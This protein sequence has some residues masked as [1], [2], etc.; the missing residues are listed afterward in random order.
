MSDVNSPGSLDTK[1]ENYIFVCMLATVPA[2]SAN[3]FV[4]AVS[5]LEWLG[6]GENFGWTGV[7]LDWS[8]SGIQPIRVLFA[9][10]LLYGFILYAFIFDRL[11]VSISALYALALVPTALLIWCES[12]I[13][14]VMQYDVASVPELTA[15]APNWFDKLSP[16]PTPL[17]G[18]DPGGLTGQAIKEYVFRITEDRHNNVAN[19]GYYVS[20]VPLIA[21]YLFKFGFRRRKLAAIFGM[22][23]A[24]SLAANYSAW[25]GSTT[26]WILASAYPV[27]C[28]ILLCVLVRFV[29]RAIIDNNEISIQNDT[30]VLGRS[31]AYWMP[32]PLTFATML[33]FGAQLENQIED[34][35][36]NPDLPLE[37]LAG[38]SLVK[39]VLSERRPRDDINILMIGHVET[40]RAAL[41]N[42][43]EDADLG[44][45]R[46]NALSQFDQIIKP[47]LEEY[48]PSFRIDG[49]CIRISLKKI[50]FSFTCLAR[51]LK[52]SILN[53]LYQI[54]KNAMRNFVARTIDGAIALAERTGTPQAAA[55]VKAQIVEGLAAWRLTIVQSLDL[56]WLLLSLI[57]FLGTAVLVQAMIRALIVIYGRL[58]VR[59]DGKDV[60]KEKNYFSMSPEPVKSSSRMV[61][62]LAKQGELSLELKEGETFY[63]KHSLDVSNA[64]RNVCLPIQPLS[65][66]FSRIWNRRYF[67][68]KIEKNNKLA[69]KIT[70]NG[71][72]RFIAIRLGK[73]D[74]VAFRWSSFVGMTSNATIEYLLS[75]RPTMLVLG[76]ARMPTLKGPGLLVVKVSGEATIAKRG[77]DTDTVAPYRLIAWDVS[78]WF[79]I[80]SSTNFFSMYVDDCQIDVLQDDKAV[81]DIAQDGRAMP[82]LFYQLWNTIRP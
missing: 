35:T 57:S 14:S 63:V 50:R 3:S 33:Y 52:N 78:A 71:S 13:G 58:L 12:T 51:D 22:S 34:W 54:P 11:R 2:I 27:A 46:K 21:F 68:K 53:S 73:D 70:D 79:R 30:R 4:A 32:F 1:I 41:Q 36:Y 59:W 69:L 40:L 47:S 39:P 49:G 31:V 29:F 7:F 80:A 44:L 64:N 9:F 60:H 65:N 56:G 6:I 37:E 23:F 5:Y 74:R 42:L 82:G 18:T 45:F 28:F 8:F 62:N 77:V 43:G 25:S 19:I 76:H 55:A 15:R 75:V 17:E 81:I 72:N 10:L 48:S 16:L 67:L 66:T 26:L 61:A 20:C 24:L 38:V